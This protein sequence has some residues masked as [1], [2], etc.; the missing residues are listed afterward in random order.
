MADLNATHD[1]DRQS[2]LESANGPDCDFPIQNL[3]HGVFCWPG[4]APRGG[5]AIGDAILDMA[6][7]VEAGLFAGIPAEAARAAAEPSLN[8]LMA[9]GNAAASALRHPSVAPNGAAGGRPSR[10]DP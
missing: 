5:V 10:T 1:P 7:A 3:P 9:M 4:E 6:T 2:W 8:R